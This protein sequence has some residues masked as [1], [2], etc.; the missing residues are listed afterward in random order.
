MTCGK[1]ISSPDIQTARKVYNYERERVRERVRER[2][3]PDCSSANNG[4]Y[5]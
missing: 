4:D 1:Y 2:S 5:N 3:M